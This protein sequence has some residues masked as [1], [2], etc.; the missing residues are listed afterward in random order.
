MMTPIAPITERINRPLV[1]KILDK[2][3]EVPKSY[4][5]NV[6]LEKVEPK[7][8]HP[9]GTVGCI[10]GWA[11][12]LSANGQGTGIVDYGTYHSDSYVEQRAQNV[13]GLTSGEADILFSP[14]SYSKW[15]TRYKLM[16]FLSDHLAA[17]RYLKHIIATGRLD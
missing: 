1:Q 2:I 7:E 10:A 14:T 17:R 6:W 11:V 12:E 13:L 15:P 3:S 9:C 5:Q 8:D 4:D 16:M